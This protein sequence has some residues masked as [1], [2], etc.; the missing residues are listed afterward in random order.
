MRSRVGKWNSMSN[1]QH[2]PHIDPRMQAAI[3]EI[4]GMILTRYPETTFSVGEPDEYGVVFVRAVVD[5][6]D[7][8]EVT[9]IYID[10][11]ID[12]LVEEG[13][14]LYV[15]PVRPPAREMALRQQQREAR[16]IPV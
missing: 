10:R 13:L 12:L 9:A 5:V 3:D 14:P 15:I 8:D 6:D 4:V 1:D 11:T 2:L 7:P 16:A